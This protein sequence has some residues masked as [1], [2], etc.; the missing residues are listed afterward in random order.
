MFQKLSGESTLR[1]VVIVTNMWGDVEHRVGEERE[2]ELKGKDKFFKPVLDQHAHL[3]RHTN[4]IGSAQRVL[5]LIL[6]NHPLPQRIQEE[7]VDQGKDIAQ[8]SAGQELDRD[9][10][11]QIRK[12]SDEMCELEEEMKQALEDKDEEAKKRLMKEIKEMKVKIKGIENDSKRMVPEYQK[13]LLDLEAHRTTI[14]QEL[15]ERELSQSAGTN[16]VLP[17][18][19]PILAIAASAA[20][21]TAVFPPVAGA[22]A[23]AV[24]TSTIIR[25]VAAWIHPRP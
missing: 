10:W 22:G 9:L 18:L 16:S 21:A 6:H 19:I 15:R 23:I 5:R 17:L 4:T 3:A 13:M 20:L 12:H 8:T 25:T 24:L 11:D 14:E 2:A 7:I 1:N